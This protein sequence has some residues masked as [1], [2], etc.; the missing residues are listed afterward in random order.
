M[1]Y[2]SKI[3]IVRK[4]HLTRDDGMRYASKL[5]EF[6]LGKVY[7]ISDKIR[8]MPKT[9]CYYYADDGDTQ[10]TA[11]RY[12]EALAE[13]TVT[14]L[15]KIIQDDMLDSDYYLYPILLATL[16]EFKRFGDSRIV[17]LHYGY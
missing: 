1:G 9:D 5:A 3:V 10:I 15:I 14:D 7:G 2:E 12:G 6:T 13:I 11:D 17:C 8:T 16:K 4:G